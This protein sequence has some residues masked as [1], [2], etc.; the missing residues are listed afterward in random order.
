VHKV[1]AINEDSS[2]LRVPSEVQML[3]LVK[4]PII[5]ILYLVFIRSI[6]DLKWPRNVSLKTTDPTSQSLKVAESYHVLANEVLE[7]ITV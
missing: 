1:R 5:Q 6:L 2:L 4:H 7:F 3:V